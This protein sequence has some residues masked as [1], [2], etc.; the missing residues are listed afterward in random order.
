LD[1]IGPY[2]TKMWCGVSLE[3][4]DGDMDLEAASRQVRR[5]YLRGFC[6]AL[7]SHI[8]ESLAIHLEAAIERLRRL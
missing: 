1:K 7:G 6:N 3:V 4:C 8:R 2:K 5:A